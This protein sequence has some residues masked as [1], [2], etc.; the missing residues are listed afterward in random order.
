MEC[1][2]AAEHLK[3]AITFISFGVYFAS[4][5]LLINVITI[6]DN[7][8]MRAI[9]FSG[10]GYGFLLAGIFLLCVSSYIENTLY[11]MAKFFRIIVGFGKYNTGRMI[12]K[13]IELFDFISNFVSLGFA[14]EEIVDN[15]D[16]DDTSNFKVFTTI[17]SLIAG[18]VALFLSF[19]TMLIFGGQYDRLI[20]SGTDKAFGKSKLRLSGDDKSNIAFLFGIGSIF[21]GLILMGI[22]LEQMIELN[23]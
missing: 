1:L 20:K 19:T 4:I 9:K 5:I 21:I 14:Y 2:K 12:I 7:Q 18:G 16:W 10:L 11:F 15:V 17:L 8:A 22:G 6:T 3:K 23:N 13:L